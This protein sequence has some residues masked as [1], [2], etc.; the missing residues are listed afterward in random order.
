MIKISEPLIGKEEK[1]E[2]VKVIESGMLVQGEKVKEFEEKFSKYVG[3]KHAIAVNSGTAALHLSLL[4][5][6]IKENDEVITS[7]FS[8]IASANSVKFC[9]GKVKFVDIKDDYNID[10][11]KIKEKINE[12]TKVIMPVHLYGNSC[13]MD[14]ILEIAKENNLKVVEDCCQAHGAEYKGKKL[15]IGDVGCFSFYPSKN[16]TTGE[17][18]M[19]V[20]N[21]DEINEKCRL[22]RDHGSKERYKHEILGYNYRMMDMNAVIGIKQLERLDEFNK[23]R[24]ENAEFYNKNLKNVKKPVTE[25][26]KKHVYHQYTVRVKNRDEVIKKLEENGI[27]YGIYYDKPIY[28]QESY[29]EDLN[30]EN[31][32]KICKEVLSLPVHPNL[33]EKDL[34]KVVEVFK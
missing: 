27:G 7:G 26:E 10:S 28:K 9:N 13:D 24:I 22:L 8:F 34:K 21:D 29:N 23:K 30:L 19:I 17:G 18:G 31:T 33:T 6:G 14:E 20:T 12:K 1:E 15:P 3:S 4:S 16:M 11:S 25:K 5:L 2:V 32:E